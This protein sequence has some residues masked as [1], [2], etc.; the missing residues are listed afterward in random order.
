MRQYSID[1]VEVSWQGLSFKEGLATGTSITE[2]RN[3]PSYTQKVNGA[4][5]RVVRIYNPD[6][7]GTMTIVV[8]QESRLHQELRAL[9][10]LDVVARNVVGPMTVRDNSNDETL[11]YQNC[12]ITSDPNETRGTDSATFEWVFAFENF[13]KTPSL[14]NANVVG[15]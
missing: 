3:A 6:R 13:V 12:Y 11:V 2:A 14:N 4:V 1:Q 10:A 7:S 9:A 8:D 5:P 15:N